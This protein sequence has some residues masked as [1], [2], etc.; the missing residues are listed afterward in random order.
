MTKSLLSLA[1]TAFI[2]GGCS[3]IPDYQTPESPVAAQWPQGPAYSPASR[4]TWPPPNKAGASSS[5]T[6]RCSS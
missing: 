6:R 2:L 4:P 3:L 5:T 1:V